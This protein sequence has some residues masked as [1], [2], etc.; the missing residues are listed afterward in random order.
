MSSI[1][2]IDSTLI[3]SVRND[4]IT[5]LRKSIDSDDKT[6]LQ[7]SSSMSS[8]LNESIHFLSSRHINTSELI[9]RS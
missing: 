4:L 3:D 6:I 5:V 2:E 7:V 8:N 9:D 1:A